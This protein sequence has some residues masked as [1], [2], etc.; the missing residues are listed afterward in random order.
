[1]RARRRRLRRRRRDGVGGRDALGHRCGPRSRRRGRAGARG[2]ARRDPDG[3][4]PRPDD[5]PLRPRRRARGRR[6]VASDRHRRPRPARRHGAPGPTGRGR[7]LVLADRPPAVRPRRRGRV[8]RRRRLDGPR[9][10]PPRAPLVEVW[11]A[12]R[13][14]VRGRRA[15]PR[16]GRG[17]TRR[18]RVR[19]GDERRGDD[20]SPL[21]RDGVG[22]R[23]GR[24]VPR[25]ELRRRRGRVRG[26]VPGCASSAPRP[27]PSA[28]RSHV[29]AS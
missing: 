16:G 6:A 12:R 26:G 27:R 20:R 19:E 28:P 1:M 3:R 8:V 18:R 14:P 5:V 17:R 13:G 2:G 11:R 15:P 10:G 23:G 9:P 24:L 22:A 4:D 25:V 21:A 7:P 29:R